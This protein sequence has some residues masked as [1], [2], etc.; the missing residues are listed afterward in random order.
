[1]TF[2][3]TFVLFFL[4]TSLLPLYTDEGSPVLLGKATPKLNADGD[5]VL[6]EF[7]EEEMACQA[8][9][10]FCWNVHNVCRLVHTLVTIYI[11]AWASIKYYRIRKLLDQGEPEGAKKGAFAGVDRNWITPLD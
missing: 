7:G 2:G 5:P 11:V 10:N 9:T 3:D 8:F 4:M 1:M 6:D